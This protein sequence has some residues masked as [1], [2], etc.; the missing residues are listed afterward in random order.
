MSL[1]VY[2]LSLFREIFVS[3]HRS[4]EFRAKIFAAMLLAKKSITDDDFIE[5]C[6][7]AKE[8]YPDSK[9][10]DD[11]L[12]ATTKEF[13]KKANEYK[14]LSLDFL[15]KDIDNELKKHKRYVA[16]IDFS[17]LRRLISEEENEALLQQRVYEF[18]VSE[19]KIYS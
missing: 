4:L 9:K 19:V 3:H 7:I 8:I 16:K 6:E 14:N 2:F 5:L 15:L 13:I 1:K 17:H 11:I 10:R 12:V 18:F